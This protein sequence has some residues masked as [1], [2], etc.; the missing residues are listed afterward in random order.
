[1]IGIVI[2]L[3]VL[4]DIIAVFMQITKNMPENFFFLIMLR[5]ISSKTFLK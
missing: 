2:V 4:M 1:M 5:S 3:A